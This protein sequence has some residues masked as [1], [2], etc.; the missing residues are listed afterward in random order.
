M[1][2]H[3]L[4]LAVLFISQS[5]L[6]IDPS[7]DSILSQLDLMMQHADKFESIKENKIKTLKEKTENIQT[8][9]ELYWLNKRLFDEYQVYNSDS[10]LAYIEKDLALA[11]QLNKPAWEME[12]KIKKSFV[13]SA[14]GLLSEA[15]EE[16]K[17]ISPS[18]LPP[19]LQTAYYGQ[20]T[21][22]YSHF[23]MYMGD[24]AE[25]KYYEIVKKYRDST[26]MV[27]RKEDP[28][29][30]WYTGWNSIETD[31]IKTVKEDLIKKLASSAYDTRLDAMNAYLLSHI[32]TN[33]GNET[34]A[35]KYL[36]YS[37]MA[38]MRISNKDIASMEELGRTLFSKG[39]IDHAYS[40]INYC[41]KNAQ[42]YNNRV[43]MLNT[44]TIQDAIYQANMER[45][46]EQRARLRVFL[47]VVSALSLI[48]FMLLFYISRQMKRLAQSR[49]KLDEMNQLLGKQ[50]EEMSEMHD[51]LLSKKSELEKMNREVEDINNQL[52]ESN[53]VKEEYI[54][55]IFNIC[56]NY[57][58]KLDEYRKEINRKIK[59]RQF[60]EIKKMTDIPTLAKTEL[61]EFYQNF[62]EIFLCIYPDFVKDFNS[63]LR[64][65]E[66]IVL[67]EGE[68]LNTELRIY[69]LVRLGIMDSVRI[70]E[71]L[72][73][74]PQTVY[75][76]RL[77]IRNRAIGNKD[78]FADMVRNLGK[79]KK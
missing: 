41:L 44:T 8:P 71:F 14:T 12:W 43:R 77:K 52:L 4:V 10:A 34:E 49:S 42:K 57:I 17:D 21:Y 36:V 28:L 9:E 53:Y 72:H 30:L 7:I 58:N 33:E 35:M 1:K 50:M 74:S 27:V 79:S 11:R 23:R 62:D 31:N 51:K 26:Q 78:N 73:C 70:A 59:T 15:M 60:E 3:F 37:A 2:S 76:N 46:H 18:M 6:G 29:Y 16:L 68:Q 45:N 54:G 48:L 5:C 19:D 32:Y 25:D 64:D 13:L 24:N 61:K 75:N 22:L 39:D 55:Y 69:A 63:L 65:D 20:M 40:Y 66:Q 38:D 47:F 56:S 67:K